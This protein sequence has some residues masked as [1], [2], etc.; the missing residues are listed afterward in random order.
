MASINWLR[1]NICMLINSKFYSYYQSLKIPPQVPSHCFPV[2]VLQQLLRTHKHC[3]GVIKHLLILKFFVWMDDCCHGCRILVPSI[4]VWFWTCYT[5]P[6]SRLHNN[7]SLWKYPET[8]PRSVL[9]VHH[10]DPKSWLATNLLLWPSSVVFIIYL[11]GE[12]IA[13]SK[14]MLREVLPQILCETVIGCFNIR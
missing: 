6:L 14:T 2:T 10:Q 8:Q 7:V 13:A 1:W 9:R 3:P 5:Y 11:L 4:W 12:N